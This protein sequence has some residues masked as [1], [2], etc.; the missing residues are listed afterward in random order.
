MHGVTNLLVMHFSFLP[1]YISMWYV[2]MSVVVL[3][4]D[5]NPLRMGA[6][7]LFLVLCLVLVLRYM[8]A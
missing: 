8:Y 2:F 3:A 4:P 1:F 6:V 5:G 7:G